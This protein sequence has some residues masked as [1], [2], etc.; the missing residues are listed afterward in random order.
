M[1]G[2]VRMVESSADI[3]MIYARYF[4]YGS[5]SRTR[6][7]H[8]S[9]VAMSGHVTASM[10]PLAPFCVEQGVFKYLCVG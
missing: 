3:Q 10:D 5:V 4:E 7:T 9:D 6:G 8:I 1:A 2:R